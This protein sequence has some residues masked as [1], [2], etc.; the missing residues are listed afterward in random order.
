MTMNNMRQDCLSENQESNLDHPNASSCNTEF[1]FPLLC[2]KTSASER[3][4]DKIWTR[5]LNI[6][7]I[8]LTVRA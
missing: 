2:L 6:Y 4:E 3:F 8:L 1:W 5:N 7:A